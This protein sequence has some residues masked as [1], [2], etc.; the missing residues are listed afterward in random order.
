MATQ[1]QLLAE[2]Q[3]HIGESNGIT[4]QDLG[5]ALGCGPREVRVLISIL[6][7]EGIAICGTPA[8]GYYIAANAEELQQTCDFLHSRAMT[9]LLLS[10]RMQKLPMADLLGQLRLPT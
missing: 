8:H 3:K 5:R 2:L 4:A 1:D 9:S 10:S 6:R 7:L